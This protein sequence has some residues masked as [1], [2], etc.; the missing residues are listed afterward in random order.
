MLDAVRRRR[1]VVV[2]TLDAGSDKPI[3][4]ATHEGEENPALGVRGLRLSFDNP[5]LLERQLDGIAGGRPAD[6]HRDL[7]D[8]ADGGHRRR[9][10]RT[11]PTQVRARGPQ[12]RA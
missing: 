2:R 10:G 9:G 1:Y 12:G 4:F 3:A 6:R 7:G 11:S 8:G 5:G